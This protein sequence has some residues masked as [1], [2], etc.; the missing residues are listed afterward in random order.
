M[1]SR[2][3]EVRHERTIVSKVNNKLWAK[4]GQHLRVDP[5]CEDAKR[6]FDGR[7]HLIREVKD[8]G[9]ECVPNPAGLKVEGETFASPVDRQ[10]PSGGVRKRKASKKRTKKVEEGTPE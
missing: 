8:E 5:D 2:V 1:A 6:E 7:W 4:W 9:Q 3:Y 10:M